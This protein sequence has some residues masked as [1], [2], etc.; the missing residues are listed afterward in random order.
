MPTKTKKRTAVK[1]ADAKRSTANNSKANAQ[2]TAQ[3]GIIAA[4]M[5][6]L[7]DVR[8]AKRTITAAEL[9]AKLSKQFASRP[10]GGLQTT[11][12]AQLSRLPSE[13]N[14]GIVKTRDGVYTQY[15]AAASAKRD[16]RRVA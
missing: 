6:T 13:R 9:L 3:P 1:A 8:D 14:F 7:C 16:A 2:R 11:M 4:L 15:A 12:R 10:V 5:H